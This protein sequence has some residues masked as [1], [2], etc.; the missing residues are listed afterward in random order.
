MTRL[1]STLGAVNPQRHGLLAWSY[2]PNGVSTGTLLTNGTLYV[3]KVH[4]AIAGTAT[5]LYWH[6]TAQGATPTSS[7]NWVGLYDTA[8]TKLVQTDVAADVA[9]TSGLKT[10]TISSTSLGRDTSYYV[11]FLFNAATA[12][13]VG[14]GTATN[15]FA[16]LTNVGLA[17]ADLRFAVAAT[18]QTSLPSTITPGSFSST[19]CV[20]LWGALG[21]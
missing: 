3:S 18:S 20:A 5:K 11:A 14:R 7:Q 4:V 1:A 2:D 12:P 8:G 17:A 9:A 19:N 16:A 15:G 13:T 10:T 6:V 21:P